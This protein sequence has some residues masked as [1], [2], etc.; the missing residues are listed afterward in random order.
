LYLCEACSS[1][2]NTMKS[3]NTSRLQTLEEDL[4][5]CL[6]TIRPRTRNNIRHHQAHDSH[7][8]LS[9]YIK[10]PY[11]YPCFYLKNLYYF[12]WLL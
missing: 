7:W 1:A 11:F 4:R 2:T 12:L 6:S 10:T 8:H 3:K 9:A 5:V